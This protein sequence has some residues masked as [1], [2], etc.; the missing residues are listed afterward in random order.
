VRVFHDLSL[1]VSFVLPP[2]LDRTVQGRIWRKSSIFTSCTVKPTPSSTFR[3]FLG[4]RR[5]AVAVDSVLCSR[6]CSVSAVLEAELG[7]QVSFSS[8]HPKNSESLDLLKMHVLLPSVM[9]TVPEPPRRLL[10][11]S[12]KGH[13]LH[14]WRAAV[15]V[16][17]LPQSAGMMYSNPQS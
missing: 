5:G 10:L 7:R 2:A 17:V 15:L 13:G 1:C 8:A 4:A 11:I 3:P 14:R 9:S 6:H 16:Q 12:L